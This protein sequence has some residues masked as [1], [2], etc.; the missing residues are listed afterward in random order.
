VNHGGNVVLVVSDV[1]SL[2]GVPRAQYATYRNAGGEIDERSE[3]LMPDLIVDALIG[4]GLRCAP[5]GRL[6]DL[7]RWASGTGAPILSLDIPSG[8]DGT[9]GEIP[10]AAVVPN[11]TMTLALPKTGL[12]PR[13]TGELF[14]GDLG[15]PV[16]TYRRARIEYLSPFRGRHVIA[17]RGIES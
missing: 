8:V 15:I 2:S 12:L 7:I 1:A 17:L 3:S 5:R 11:W 14:L 16:E 9:T 10:G 13:R 6:A 4:Y